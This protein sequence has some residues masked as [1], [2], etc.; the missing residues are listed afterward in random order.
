MSCKKGLSNTLQIVERFL[1]ESLQKFFQIEGRVSAQLYQ[2]TEDFDYQSPYAMMYFKRVRNQGPNGP[3]GSIDD[4]ADYLK[5]QLSKEYSSIFSKIE[6]CE[7]FLLL[8]MHQE[9][10]KD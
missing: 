9:Y 4:L 7:K 1:S 6:I 3:F 10:L 2:I 8:Q 5:I